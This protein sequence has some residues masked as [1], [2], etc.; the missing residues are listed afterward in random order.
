[1]EVEVDRPPNAFAQL[2]YI[3]L[4]D[5][6]AGERIVLDLSGGTRVLVSLVALAAFSRPEI[7]E[8]VAEVIWE[9]E[10]AGV[11]LRLSGPGLR[12]LA[13]QAVGGPSKAEEAVLRTLREIGPARLAEIHRKLREK[14]YTWTK[15]YTHKI[16][17]KLVEGG[18]VLK[19][20][21]GKYRAHS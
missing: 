1:M 21:R 15:Q 14:E 10:G 4:E 19:T 8:A 12:G 7:V 16:L 6:R 3:L 9:V 18:V 13:S 2:S 17:T 5:A 20:A 11:E